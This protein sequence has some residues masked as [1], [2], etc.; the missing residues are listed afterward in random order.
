MGTSVLEGVLDVVW[1]GESGTSYK[2]SRTFWSWVPFLQRF[3]LEKK[4]VGKEWTSIF[5]FGKVERA[6]DSG[7][8]LLVDAGMFEHMP[9]LPGERN[10]KPVEFGITKDGRMN[11]IGP[12]PF[13]LADA[14]NSMNKPKNNAMNNTGTPDWG[15]DSFWTRCS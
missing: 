14:M 2:L 10:W 3:S 5:A 11:A 1:C 15:K 9:W 6:D 13:N 12:A 7:F 4:P 8:V